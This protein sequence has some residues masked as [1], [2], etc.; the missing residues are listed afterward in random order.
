MSYTPTEENSDKLSVRPSV[1][2]AASGFFR[3]LVRF[4]QSCWLLPL[5]AAGVLAVGVVVTCAAEVVSSF[6]GETPW[7]LGIVSY[8]GKGL[9]FIGV[10]AG[11]SVPL[12]LVV[13]TVVWLRREELWEVLCCWTSSALAFI[14]AYL[15]ALWL[16]F[17]DLPDYY[18][19]GLEVPAD[20]E[21]VIPRGMTFNTWEQSLPPAVQNLCT[22]KPAETQLPAPDA[23]CAALAAPHA[24]KL[25][26]EAP[27]LLSEYLLRC[28]YAEATNPRFY[29]PLLGELV[30]VTHADTP[31]P[32]CRL[33]PSEDSAETLLTLSHGWR[34]VSRYHIGIPAA[35]Q[36]VRR[37]DK[38]LIP[39]AQN[40][41]CEQLDSL[42]APVPP[43]P[44]LCLRECGF[45]SYDALIVIP[46]DFPEG[47]FELRAHEYTTGKNI[48]F[49]QCWCQEEKIGNV[50]RIIPGSGA[51]PLTVHSGNQGEYYGSVWEIWFSPASG[52]EPRC[53][54][55]QFFLM[56]G[57]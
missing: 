45:G 55:R 48:D 24:E 53:V 14:V 38:A 6:L 4:V 43:K 52:G 12:W 19:C 23:L 50:C 18:A 15:A 39:A 3:G 34:V 36:F 26:R 22:M 2:N 32:A 25:A 41:T 37:L 1:T 11:L 20:K 28:L 44:F 56:M 13:M 35:E 46:A 5:G 9:F 54:N 16:I 40:P 42:L 30:F 27:E 21:F 51:K 8:V 29:S 49:Q 33:F 7:W 57:N 17:G 31:P 10:A 47:V